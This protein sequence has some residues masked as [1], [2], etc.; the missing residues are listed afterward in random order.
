MSK[1][2][3]H[4]AVTGLNAIDSPGPG[5]GVIRA[6]R[7]LKGYDIRIVGLS[8][9]ALEPG[10][11]MRDLVDKTYQIPYP[12]AGSQPLFERLEY[13]HAREN[14]HMVFPNFDAE[15][16][17][18]IKLAPKLSKMGIRS[19]LPG[20]EQLEMLDKLHL[21]EFG[22]EHDFLV[23]KTSYVNVLPNS[24]DL[25]EEFGFPLVIKGKFYEAYIA[26]SADQVA[27]YFHKIQAKW[28]LP[29]VLQQ[30]VSGTEVDV[31]G[32]GDGTG[33]MIGAVPMRKLYITDKGKG[34]A[35]VTLGDK[36]L[37]DL[38]RR[39]VKASKWRGGFELEIMRS[40]KDEFYILEVNPRFPAWIYTAA[41]AGQN[42]PGAA[43]RL[44]LGEKVN[45]FR[46][47]KV[48]KLFVRYAWDLVTDIEQFHILSTLGEL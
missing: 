17:N 21:Y 48:G 26:Y 38:A 6:I 5:V 16:P 19:F 40:E 25:Q 36:T 33:R 10:V 13:V 46:K 29:I 43:V 31:A 27:Y 23:P 34:W 9:E 37:T 47:Y 4:I 44:A 24:R 3:L 45:T 15:L 8:Y 30:F 2:A 42:L 20:Q 1:Q 22:Q 41:A 11:Y 18:F 32:L 39:F 14:L 28:G 7:E 12:S 35:G